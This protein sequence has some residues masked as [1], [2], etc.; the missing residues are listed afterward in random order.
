MVQLSQVER[1]GRALSGMSSTDQELL[2]QSGE[3]FRRCFGCGTENLIGL[4]LQFRRE[5][6]GAR[7]EFRPR[8][9][10][11]GWDNMLHGGIILTMLD[12]TLAYAAMFA[13]GP[14]VTAEIT[15]RVRRPAP[16]DSQYRLFGQVT[17][18]RL[19]M[20]QA[21]ATIEDSSG[22]LYASADGKFMV[23]R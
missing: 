17:R 10:Y 6:D 4:R 22:V 12:E 23:M 5:D 21:R 16:L 7:A 1:F 20:I 13:V 9:E 11:Q 15:A 18:V 2:R 3:A 14:A 19:G 8:P